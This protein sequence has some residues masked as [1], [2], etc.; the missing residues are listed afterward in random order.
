MKKGI[1]FVIPL[2]VFT[3]IM[4]INAVP[5][6]DWAMAGGT[7]DRQ[8]YSSARIMPPLKHHWDT[9]REGSVY[10]TSPIISGNSV[11]LGM[12]KEP[13][14]NKYDMNIQKHNLKTG[15]TQWILK[16]AWW[17]WCA[18]GNDLIA[19]GYSVK[20]KE[21]Y[22][23]V[24]R[25]SGKDATTIWEIEWLRYTI[26]ALLDGDNI[27]SLSYSDYEDEGTK[28]HER[29][30]FFQCHS[31]INGRLLWKKSY[32]Y[33]KEYN[34]PWFC[35]FKGNVYG[36][37][38]K[39]IYKLDANNGN[40][41]WKVDIKE[42]IARGSY[43]VGTDKGI[44]YNTV[45]DRLTL[46]DPENGSA[47]WSV[48]LSKYDPPDPEE[49]G[50]PSGT[51]CVMGNK[52][53]ITTRGYKNESQPKFVKCMDLATGKTLWENSLPGTS[54]IEGSDIGFTCSGSTGVLYTMTEDATGKNTKLRAFDPQTGMLIW[55]DTLPGIPNP[56]QFALTTGYAVIGMEIPT[57]HGKSDFYYQVYT[58][59]DVEP[60]K[61][62]LDQTSINFGYFADKKAKSV[63]FV[64]GNSGSGDLMGI[65]TTNTE[66]L[67]VD[68]TQFTGN[69]ITLS[70]IADPTKMSIG[71]N[72]GSFV[73]KSNGGT[74]IVEVN[75]TFGG[76]MVPNET[77]ESV[78]VKCVDIKGWKK[79]IKLSGFNHGDVSILNSLVSATPTSFEGNDIEI[80]I[81]INPA[82]ITDSM[83]KTMVVINS[84]QF[85]MEISIEVIDVTKSKKIE[86]WVGKS[87]SLV[88]GK[89]V[90]VDPPPQIIG[91]STFVPLRFVA[92]AF[93][94]TVNYEA[95]ARRIDI[96][97]NGL[98]VVLLVGSKKA[99]VNGK[100]V[101]MT[102]A[103][104]II[105]GRTFVPI[106]FISDAFGA[107]I[108]YESSTKKITISKPG[109]L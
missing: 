89:S 14:N 48:K 61:L 4:P 97:L 70:V 86:M 57:T 34:T 18:Y 72:K 76:G 10:A 52:I 15:V 12:A 55:Q 11:Y 59:V 8:H 7:A 27:Y 83:S 3:Q 69:E 66:W 28:V 95:S 56:F 1:L 75:A 45:Y 81:T 99:S 108:N 82:Q 24:R 9:G 100:E 54:V 98:K 36:A 102:A 47:I 42:R 94:A 90:T 53:Y 79:I 6:S 105:K 44:L 19:Q 40:E 68:P 93:G 58:N 106:R 103:P 49:C 78:Q 77:K 46:M 60:P 39:T 109:C 74:S 67:L 21:G 73:I 96:S 31:A 5:T 84:N 65:V 101:P 80:A 38:Y 32:T 104:S 13:L 29:M 16:D 30:Y 25:V 26:C 35:V 20:D 43:L 62:N 64:I 88:D 51:P 92:D 41:V 23:W 71:P 37:I 87:N 22:L 17:P 63:D 2:L 33:S 107:S 85:K 91:G 50:M